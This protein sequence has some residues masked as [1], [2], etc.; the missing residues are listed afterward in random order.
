MDNLAYYALA[1][2]GIAILS[3]AIMAVIAYDRFDRLQRG[4]YGLE[5][6]IVA[7]EA[8][9]NR[10]RSQPDNAMGSHRG[11]GTDSADYR[12][13]LFSQERQ[14]PL[15]APPSRA[16]APTPAHFTDPSKPIAE[17]S[18][19]GEERMRYIAEPSV[20][21]LPEAESAEAA[22]LFSVELVQSIYRTWCRSSERPQSTSGVEVSPLEYVRIELSSEIGARPRHIL[23]TA[24]QLSEFVRFS[25]P[26]ATSG[27]VLPD[28]EAHYSPVVAHLFPGLSRTE[29]AQTESLSALTPVQVKK[30]GD[31]SEWVQA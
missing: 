3:V 22:D 1:A 16:K 10:Q 29:F 25:E 13:T 11:M 27:L 26:G 2:G 5:K 7:V 21:H 19:T 20:S 9:L 18:P 28:V 15:H 31:T 17:V 24:S 12:V 30:R 4:M 14:E 6:K 8:R 23:R